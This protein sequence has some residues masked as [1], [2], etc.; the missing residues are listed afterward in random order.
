MAKQSRF[1]SNILAQPPFKDRLFIGDYVNFVTEIVAKCESISGLSLKMP[2][3]IVSTE[4]NYLSTAK[5]IKDTLSL[6]GV[7]CD[8]FAVDNVQSLRSIDL[9]GGS[10]IIGVGDVDFL[11]ALLLSCKDV[12]TKKLA[13]PNQG[14]FAPLFCKEKCFQGVSGDNLCLG[15]YDY[16]VLDVNLY[17]RLKKNHV[18]DALSFIASK[19]LQLLE[20]KLSHAD[21]G[22]QKLDGIESLIRSATGLIGGVTEENMYAVSI[23]AQ[24]II[25]KAIYI[26]S[27][28]YLSP[29]YYPARVLQMLTGNTLDECLFGLTQPLLTAYGAYISSPVQIFDVPNVNDDVEEFAETMHLK[30]ASVLPFITISDLLQIEGARA[31]AGKNIEDVIVAKKCAKAHKACYDRVY[32]GRKRRDTFTSEQLYKALTLG[33]AVSYGVLKTMYDDG[34]IKTLTQK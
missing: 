22:K 26:E 2:V 24:I 12:P 32:R 23:V 20:L 16:V 4:Q 14:V 17:K 7:F 11:D 9:S 28:I 10:L 1:L 13:I 34:F 29:S 25:A 21:Y 27:Q 3:K 6:K 33:G 31:K 8:A 19:N 15:L 30:S 5:L 18:A